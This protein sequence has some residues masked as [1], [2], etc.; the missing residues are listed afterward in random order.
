MKNKLTIEQL[1]FY[2]SIISFFLLFCSSCKVRNLGIELSR[3]FQINQKIDAA[4]AQMDD[5]DIEQADADGFEVYEVAQAIYDFTSPNGNPLKTLAYYPMGKTEPCPVVL[6]SHGLT[7]SGESQIY[8]LKG[9]ARRGFIV[10]APDHDDYINYDR[11]GLLDKKSDTQFF[12]GLAYAVGQMISALFRESA[13]FLS[14]LSDS[15]IQQLAD[16]GELLR[17]FYDEFDYR[18]AD[19]ESLL[20]KL[21]KM[22]EN[23]QILAGKIDLARII[24]AGHSLGG[25]TTLALAMKDSRIKTAVCLSPASHPFSQNDLS[26]IKAPILYM[27][28]DLDGFHDYILKAYEESPAPKMLQSISGGG[29]YIFTDRPFFYGVGLPFLSDGAD[30]IAKKSETYYPEQLQDYQLKAIAISR[31]V[32]LFVSAYADDNENSLDLLSETAGN[33][34]IAKSHIAQ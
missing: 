12:S 13:N 15:E 20:D 6:F 7:G 33:P 16:A 29:H 24:M 30:G 26:L 25:A 1:L 31:T 11:I 18:L 3:C 14:G 19:M 8:L 22:N 21:P 34:F 9:L 23:D 28:G 27:T 17:E 10:L 2:F 5:L 32:S 4:K